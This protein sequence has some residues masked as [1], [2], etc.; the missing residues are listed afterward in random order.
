L[1]HFWGVTF[2][3]VLPVQHLMGFA[4][5]DLL[6]IGQV[7]STTHQ[8]YRVS[9]SFFS[10]WRYYTICSLIELSVEANG[11]KLRV[12]AHSREELE[13]AIKAAQDFIAA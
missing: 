9:V 8:E 2:E 7:V 4:L 1:K 3:P 6:S 11:K 13:A 12:K 5:S 10:V